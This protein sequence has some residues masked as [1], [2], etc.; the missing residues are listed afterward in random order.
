MCLPVIAAVAAV[1]Q[2]AVGYAAAKQQAD[3]QNAFYQENAV[4]A[5]TAA[6]NSYQNL[7]IR[8]EQERAAADQKA[9]ENAIEAL[10]ARGRAQVAAG[11]SGVT[12]LSID[13]LVG[14]L[15]QQ[16]GRNW[17]AIDTNLQM[18]EGNI[19]TEMDNVKANAQGRI[20]SVQRA[21]SPSPLPFIFQGLSGAVG[22]F[23]KAPAPQGSGSF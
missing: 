3:E 21:S 15:F 4:A 1:G 14:D 12:G 16:E 22:S 18:T 9:Q 2:A 10:K 17:L 19:R 13:A 20:N 23:A 6:V 11:E 7:Q 5:R 8:Q